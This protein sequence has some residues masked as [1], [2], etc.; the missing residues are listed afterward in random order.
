M[1]KESIRLKGAGDDYY[2]RRIPASK[3][4][5]REISPPRFEVWVPVNT[6]GY[7]NI[8]LQTG[9]DRLFKRLSLTSEVETGCPDFDNKYFITCSNKKEVRAYFEHRGHRDVILSLFEEGYNEIELYE[10]KLLARHSEHREEISDDGNE[11]ISHGAEKLMILA[12]GL[13]ESF[14]VG[15]RLGAVS[16]RAINTY[17]STVSTVALIL[18][19]FAMIFLFSHA[20]VLD[21]DAL[22]LFSL[23]AALPFF[24]SSL[25][26]LYIFSRRHS[27]RGFELLSG[28][29][30]GG[31]ALLFILMGSIFYMNRYWDVS[32]VAGHEVLVVEKK[33]QRQKNNTR[34]L[35]V[36]KS[37]R[38]EKQTKALV[39]NQAFYDWVRPNQTRLVV[40]T[41]RGFFNHE[42]LVSFEAAATSGQG[43]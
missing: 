2:F 34:Y 1:K 23:Q 36:T 20:R 28:Y 7:F 37:W 18:G 42:W 27:I 31:L 38:D 40:Y 39:T 25:F 3:R 43:R 4:K 10:Q 21:G 15:G 22:G 12:A 19:F 9:F 41:K 17:L 33:T 30:L 13:E 11:L 26:L 32:E 8:T 29:V 16:L 24:V 35:L 5:G 6:S 14:H